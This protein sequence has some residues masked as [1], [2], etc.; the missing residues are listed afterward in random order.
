MNDWQKKC[1][2]EGR[3][4]MN[5]E[6]KA[7]IS[8]INRSARDE[9]LIKKTGWEE[10]NL[11]A[12]SHEKYQIIYTLSG[13]LHIQIGTMNY[14]VPEKHL[15]WI[16]KG[17]EH[18]LSSKSRQVSL[19]IFFLSLDQT[20]D[21]DHL[22]ER[23]AI[24]MTN[25]VVAENLKFIAS[26]GNMISESEAPDLF[27]FTLSFFR[28]LPRIVPGTGFLL[29]TV[30]IPDDSRLYP[31]LSYITEHISE[32]IKMEDIARIFNLSVR[33]LSRLFQ[34]SGLHFSS[35]VNHLRIVRAI[36]LLTDGG[37]NMKEIAYDVG[38]S[39][40]NHFNRVFKQVT[41]L[42]PKVYLHRVCQN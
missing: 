6:Q 4:K 41:E 32:E 25:T 39:T 26:R 20:G 17:A 24:Y 36:E 5:A 8:L 1:R 10:I 29:K 9:I 21:E 22:R 40:P 12:H 33:N 23:F 7:Y 11:V 28:L 18:K 14:F 31:V 42:S 27:R 3:E 34:T 30:V 13:T 37:K 16:P 35:Y 19:I 38:F 15:A 2:S